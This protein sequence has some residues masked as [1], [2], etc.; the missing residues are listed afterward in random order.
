MAVT[1]SQSPAWLP[2]ARLR[3]AA[4][5]VGP[6]LFLVVLALLDVLDGSIDV[7][8]HELGRAGWLMHLDFFVFGL[9]VLAL[10]SVVPRALR[11]GRLAGVGTGLLCLWGLG[12]LLATF[13]LDW[14]NGG[15]PTT[16]HGTLHFLGFLL[17]ALAP[18]PTLFVFAWLF[19]RDERWRGFQWYSL[20]MGIALVAVVFGP[21]TS[22][23]DAYPIWTGPASM[24]ELA[25]AC[26]WLEL[27]AIRLWRLSGRRRLEEDRGSRRGA[28]SGPAIIEQA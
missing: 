10:A 4:G 23:G 26:A 2:S 14:Q 20:L 24:L 3:T 18:I 1:T 17:V 6:V 7:S 27:V 25:L 15:P 22:E 13:T 8:A 19:R 9:L 11:S 12:P 16:W 21:P 5:M 28:L